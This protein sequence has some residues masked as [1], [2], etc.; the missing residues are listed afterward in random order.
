MANK[1]ASKMTGTKGGG[2]VGIWM[3]HRME[4]NLLKEEGGGGGK[5]QIST[6]E[7]RKG[8]KKGGKKGKKERKKK[9]GKKRKKGKEGKQ[10]NAI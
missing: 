2:G 4:C 1:D 10:T 6:F 8:R 7:E 5:V 3:V 9:K